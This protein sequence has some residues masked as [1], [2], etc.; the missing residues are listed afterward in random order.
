MAEQ[1]RD[2]DLVLHVGV[3][4]IRQVFAD[5][6]VEFDLPLLDQLPDRHR[7]EHLV[8]RPEVELGVHPDRRIPRPTR[9]PR[10]LLVQRLSVAGDEHRAGEAPRLDQLVDEGIQALDDLGVGEAVQAD[11]VRRRHRPDHKPGNRVGQ[12]RLDGHLDPQPGLGRPGAR[13]HGDLRRSRPLHDLDVE[14]AGLGGELGVPDGVPLGVVLPRVERVDLGPGSRVDCGHPGV[15]LLAGRR[16]SEL[17]RGEDGNEQ[18]HHHRY[19]TRSRRD[20]SPPSRSSTCFCS[21]ARKLPLATERRMAARSCSVI[22]ALYATVA[23]ARNAA[24]SPCRFAR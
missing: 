7:G 17:D 23:A 16:A 9:Q 13:D 6:V 14:A 1:V 20:L 2:G 19:V 18:E 3:G 21:A 22:A 11:R 8:H 10:R 4:E 24:L 15:E 5:L 12:R